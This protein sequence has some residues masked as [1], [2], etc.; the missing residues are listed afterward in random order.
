MHDRR[1]AVDL[2]RVMVR[3][4]PALREMQEIDGREDAQRDG[5]PQAKHEQRMGEVMPVEVDDV[6]YSLDDRVVRKPRGDL[7]EAVREEA[8]RH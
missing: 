5:G 7:T 8:D 3:P 6:S 2:A 1:G 4:M